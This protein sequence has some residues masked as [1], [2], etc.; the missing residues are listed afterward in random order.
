MILGVETAHNIS[1]GNIGGLLPLTIL[2][3]AIQFAGT[4][5]YIYW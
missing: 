3:Y 1:F 4:G 5:F 2:R